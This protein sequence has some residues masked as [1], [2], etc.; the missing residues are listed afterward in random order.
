MTIAGTS[1]ATTTR[2][3]ADMVAKGALL[4]SGERRYARYRA[5]IELGPVRPV[6][7]YGQGR[8]VET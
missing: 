8:I 4:R 5:N 7:V 6:T 3:L 2:A 1:I